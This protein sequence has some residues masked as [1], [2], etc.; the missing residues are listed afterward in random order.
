MTLNASPTWSKRGQYE[1]LEF[2]LSSQNSPLYPPSMIRRI[3]HGPSAAA[4]CGHIGTV[5]A[6]TADLAPPS[7]FAVD[8]AAIASPSRRRPSSARGVD[9]PDAGQEQAVM[10]PV[11]NMAALRLSP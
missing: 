9:R 10:Q 1:F 5:T 8:H 11:P 3:V 7:R 6:A 2:A 4:K